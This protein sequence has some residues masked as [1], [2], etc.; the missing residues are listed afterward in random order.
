MSK[1]II[2]IDAGTTGIR[3]IAFDHDSNIL[4]NAYSEFTQYF[5]EPG[6]VEHDADE[7]WSSQLGVAVEA[8]NKIGASADDIAAIATYVRGD[9]PVATVK[10]TGTTAVTSADLPA[11][12]YYITTSTGSVV[13]IDSTNGNV[14]VDDKNTI[15]VLNK[16]IT[17]PAIISITDEG[18]KALAQIGTEVAYKVVI[19]V[20][21][22]ATNYVF[23]DTMDDGLTLVANSV[24]TDVQNATV[25]YNPGHN[26]TFTITFPAGLTEG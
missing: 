9:T 3:A 24:R 4:S 22:G 5:P 17:G 14:T 13:T 18:K 20:G 21:K 23:H 8:M 25:N 11:G 12:Y 7:I 2:G 16:T 19:T 10:A 26:E 15:P 6:W 1:Y